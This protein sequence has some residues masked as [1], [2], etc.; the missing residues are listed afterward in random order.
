MFVTGEPSAADL[1]TI[2]KLAHGFAPAYLVSVARERDAP[3]VAAP[4]GS[5][6]IA[7]ADGR[8]FVGLRAGRRACE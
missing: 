3:L 5:R 6:A 8:R 1:L 4:R 7:C 2:T